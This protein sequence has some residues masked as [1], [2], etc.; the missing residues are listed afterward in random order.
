MGCV[1][2]VSAVSDIG[3]VR[4]NNEDYY[5][6]IRVGDDALIVTVADGV[7]GLQSGEV[8][9]KLGA[10]V[11]TTEVAK[12][13]AS[14]DALIARGPFD[15]DLTKVA[16]EAVNRANEVIRGAVAGSGTTLVSAI[17]LQKTCE[18]YIV[19]VGDS[20]AYLIDPYEIAQLTRDHSIAW[21][22]YES[23]I[24]KALPRQEVKLGSGDFEN[25]LR[26][27]SLSKLM[28]IINHPRAHVINNVVGYFGE[29]GFVDVFR[30]KLMSGDILLLT[31]DGL[32]DV[33]DDYEIWMLLRLGRSE[34]LRELIN[35]VN[36]RGGPDNITVALVRVKEAR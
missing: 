20:R 12:F 35:V 11:F 15:V 29:V 5:A 4:G 34:A 36:R 23:S 28:N 17:L 3:R 8:A 22:D 10:V 33:L 26:T 2:E 24:P 18:A 19:N 6:F 13:I 9:S 27:F 25:W 32:T 21:R 14:Y 31:T 16:Y 1:F 30:V 7:G